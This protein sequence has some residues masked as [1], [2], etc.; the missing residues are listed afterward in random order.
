MPNR[1]DVI[2]SKIM[3][4]AYEESDSNILSLDKR[5]VV[6][7]LQHE[8]EGLRLALDLLRES[9]FYRIKAN[10]VDKPIPDIDGCVDNNSII[11][12]R[13][14]YEGC[15]QAQIE[16]RLRQ[17]TEIFSSYLQE[18]LVPVS[19][20]RFSPQKFKEAITNRFYDIKEFHLSHQISRNYNKSKIGIEA[21][22]IPRWLYVIP[23]LLCL[24]VS[25]RDLKKDYD[26]IKSNDNVTNKDR[27]MGKKMQMILGCKFGDRGKRYTEENLV[28]AGIT[29]ASFYNLLT[30]Q[31]Y[32]RTVS[33][34]KKLK[35]IFEIEDAIGGDFA[36]ESCFSLAEDVQTP[37][38]TRTKRGKT[39]PRQRQ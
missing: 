14:N 13:E 18:P 31:T 2:L 5:K 15:I 25:I 32:I 33:L 35:K 27:E 22:S 1:T 38:R 3:K 4:N 21:Y 37:K 12:M 16:E 39:T 34:W 8:I 19:S 24:G 36:I 29:N 20:Y 9:G 7:R 11:A 23:I 17:I 30:E 10:R 6:E 26:N 28:K